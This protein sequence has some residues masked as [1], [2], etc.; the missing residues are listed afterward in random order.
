MRFR[1]EHGHLDVPAS[2]RS[3]DSTELGYWL[4]MQRAERDKLAPQ[5]VK[6]LEKAGIE[7]E[8]LSAHERK[9]REG[10]AAA[11]RYHAA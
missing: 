5:Q 8:A 9:W 3:P 6:L 1:E 11:T 2:Y 7:W 4:K 10:L